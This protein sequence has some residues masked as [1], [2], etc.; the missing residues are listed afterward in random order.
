MDA[1]ACPTKTQCTAVGLT[2]TGRAFHGAE[3]TFNPR[4]G[5]TVKPNLVD[6]TTSGSGGGQAIPKAVAC[7]S[8]MQCTLVDPDGGEV[9]FDPLSSK[10]ISVG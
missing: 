2:P 4:S 7:P 9:T 5:A 3:A 1:V 10:L 6:V 8:R